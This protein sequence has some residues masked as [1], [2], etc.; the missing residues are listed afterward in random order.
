VD[1]EEDDEED[2]NQDLL[3][4]VSALFGLDEQELS[5]ET[6]DGVFSKNPT[7]LQLLGSTI[8]AEENDVEVF[9]E[10]IKPYMDS[11]TA[12]HGDNGHE[13][14]AWPLIKECLPQRWSWWR[15]GGLASC[16]E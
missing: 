1:D 4:I 14:A 7:V 6:T 15:R 13:F 5:K 2:V 3:E 11:V 9:S 16:Q 12:D 8:S 10:K